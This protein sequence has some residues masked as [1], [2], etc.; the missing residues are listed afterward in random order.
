[1]VVDGF[2]NGL[3]GFFFFK[4]KILCCQLMLFFVN[5]RGELKLRLWASVVTIINYRA[6][7]IVETPRESGQLAQGQVSLPSHTK[8][9]RCFRTDKFNFKKHIQIFMD[10]K[11]SEEFPWFLYDESS[12]QGH[13]LHPLWTV[14]PGLTWDPPRSHW[15]PGGHRSSPESQKR[16]SRGS[17]STKTADQ[18]RFNNCFNIVSIKLFQ[19]FLFKAGAFQNSITSFFLQT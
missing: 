14:S 17:C 7:S 15:Q 19:V 4:K 16:S 18:H 6:S 1:M 5:S 2:W 10:L 11:W 13:R 3:E 8:K 9:T 12:P